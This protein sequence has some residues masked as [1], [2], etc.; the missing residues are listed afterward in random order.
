MDDGCR[1][2][3]LENPNHQAAN[4]PASQPS[5]QPY[6]TTV[7]LNSAQN[8]SNHTL[9]VEVRV[10]AE[11]PQCGIPYFCKELRNFFI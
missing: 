5:N 6:P 10:I 7:I 11:P 1:P 8:S 3:I 9:K 2:H 4:Q